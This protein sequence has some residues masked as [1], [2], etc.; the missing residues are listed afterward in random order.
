MSFDRYN[1]TEGGYLREMKY[2]KEQIINENT[3]FLEFIK[4]SPTAFQTVETISE[5]LEKSGFSQKRETEYGEWQKS[6]NVHNVGGHGAKDDTCRTSGAEKGGAIK[7]YVIRG[8]SSLIAFYVPEKCALKGFKL[9]CAHTDSPM[10]KFKENGEYEGAGGSL[11]INVEKYGGMLAET[12]FDRPLSAAGRI[13]TERGEKLESVLVNL[14]KPYFVIPNLAVHMSRQSGGNDKKTLS[15]QNI[16]QPIAADE[17]IYALIE[18][19]TGISRGEIL[20]SD[21]YLYNAQEGCIMGDSMVCAPRIDDLQCVFGALK[22]FLA[23]ISEEQKVG[24]ESEV[25]GSRENA[26]S[27]SKMQ[28]VRENTSY[29]RIFAVFD[30]EE[31]GSLSRQGA[32]SDFLPSVLREL[33]EIQGASQSDFRRMLANSFMISA[34]NAH[35]VHPNFPEKADISNRPR[36]NGGIVIKYHGG[37]KY[38]TD[39]VTG[40]HIKRLCKAADIPYQIYYNNSDIAG[41]STLGN[42]V[43][44][45]LS[46]KAADV[47]FAQL[48]MHSAYETAGAWDTLYMSGLIEKFMGEEGDFD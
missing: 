29:I 15:I 24:S 46:V 44:A 17:G 27:E 7:G 9:V 21:L 18:K 47:G 45:N 31:V 11:K 28:G 1:L 39:A 22:G 5:M 6:E 43:M 48:A 23:S 32:A 37:Q 40:A 16:C 30:N 36:I 38:T 20:G 14:K 19:E 10:F 13:V 8:G 42:L 3:E 26:G 33:A 41:G 34:D 2:S 25:Q 4:K 35:A 12:W